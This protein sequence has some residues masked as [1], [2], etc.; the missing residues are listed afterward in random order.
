MFPFDEDIED[1]IEDEKDPVEYGIDFTT[2]QLTGALVYGLEAV[3]VWAWLTLQTQ[4]YVY[5]Q[6]SFNHGHELEDLIGEVHS[7]EYLESEIKRIVSDTL[8]MNEFI[9]DVTI[10]DFEVAGDRVAVSVTISTKWGDTEIN[11]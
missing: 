9:T 2:G 4:R 1:Q 5:E 11:V 3:K 10:T 6:Y 8:R 7:T